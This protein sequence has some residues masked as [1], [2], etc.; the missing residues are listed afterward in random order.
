MN[1]IWIKLHELDKERQRTIFLMITLCYFGILFLI[2]GMELNNGG[3]LFFSG[4]M[5]SL[6][7]LPLYKLEKIAY[8]Q[9]VMKTKKRGKR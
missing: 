9:G 7:Y 5:L 6:I 2:L 3:F 8:L 1:E 4:S